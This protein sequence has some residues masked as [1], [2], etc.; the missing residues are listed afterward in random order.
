VRTARSQARLAAVRARLM[1]RPSDTRAMQAIAIS[2]GQEAR[3]TQAE[4][5]RLSRIAGIQVPAN[6]VLFFPTLPLRV[7]TVKAKRGSTVSGA[8]MTV[9]NSRLAIDSSL[10]VSDRKLVRVG[11]PVTIEEQDLGIRLRGTVTRVADTPG[12]NRVDPARFYLQITPAT[13]SVR[14]VGASV[15]LTI[16]VKSTQGRVLTVPVSAL[17]VGGDGNSRVQVRRRGKIELATVLPGLAA[18]GLVEVKPIGRTRLLPGDQ[19]VVGAAKG[20]DLLAGAGGGP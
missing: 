12:T 14:L 18:K 20:G 17:S 13:G 16:A 7:D 6:E 1:A 10:S 4:V 11:D 3:R 5:S 2:A 15:K 9:T 8:V 19:V